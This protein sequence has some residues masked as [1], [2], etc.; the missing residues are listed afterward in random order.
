MLLWLAR[1]GRTWNT[2]G[3]VSGSWW[4]PGGNAHPPCR[5]PIA[6]KS[7]LVAVAA[8]SARQEAVQAPFH[9][10]LSAAG[11][12]H[13]LVLTCLS[14]LL[15]PKSQR[16]GSHQFP[17]GSNVCPLIEAARLSPMPSSSKSS[18]R[19]GMARCRLDAS[20]PVMDVSP[21]LA[22]LSPR[23]P[24]SLPGGSA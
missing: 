10:V 24:T 6:R 20:S 4:K 8:G 19:A 5:S 11:R 3:K 2:P 23:P 17:Q 9:G 22:A 15:L 16:Q 18:P 12:E 13:P 7:G 14:G 1:S 21:D